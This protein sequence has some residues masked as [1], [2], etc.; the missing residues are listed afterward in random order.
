LVSEGVLKTFDSLTTVKDFTTPF[1]HEASLWSCPGSTPPLDLSIERLTYEVQRTASE[2]FPSKWYRPQPAYV[3][4]ISGHVLSKRKHGGAMGRIIQSRVHQLAYNIPT[5][6]TCTV[7]VTLDVGPLP[8]DDN[9]ECIGHGEFLYVPA[10]GV[11]MWDET[12]LLDEYDESDDS[13]SDLMNASMHLNTCA[14]PVGLKEPFKVRVITGGPEG[15][16]YRC[17]WIQKSTH[18]RMRGHRTF[19][20]IGTPL[21]S[22]IL[23]NVI[24]PLHD[25]QF[26]VSGDYSSATDN[27]DPRLSEAAARTISLNA[28]WS[29]R[30]TKDYVDSLIGHTLLHPHNF[31]DH[32]SLSDDTSRP[33]DP[34][35]LPD[36]ALPQKW[37]QLM[38]SPT[39]FPILC[40]VNAA[41]TRYAIECHTGMF[42]SLED[43]GILINGDD[44]GFVTDPS[45]YSIWKAVT[46][47]GGLSPSPGKNFTSKEFLVLNST[48]HQAT[49]NG[50][51]F[52]PFVNYGLLAGRSETGGKVID[53][54]KAIL[55]SADP[56][57]ADLSGMS[58]DLIKGFDTPSQVKLIQ[59]FIQAWKPT[60]DALLPSGLSYY[61]PKHLGGLGL[62]VVGEWT[63][64]RERYSFQQLRMAAFLEAS[65]DRQKQLAPLTTIGRSDCFSL[66]L[67]AQPKMD[68]VL[69]GI[70]RMWMRGTV[71]Q[72]V[73][74]SLTTSILAQTY[75][76][77]EAEDLFWTDEDGDKFS[78][79]EADADAK[80]QFDIWRKRWQQ[81]WKHCTHTQFSPLSSEQLAGSTPWVE[82]YFLQ[83]TVG[84]RSFDLRH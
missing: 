19:Q 77:L 9:H 30:V 66:W 27:L 37:G 63:G 64:K 68:A 26:Y 5:P 25:D 4:S 69:H 29:E 78:M 28:G 2:V 6:K 3:P 65:P 32:S 81:I 83:R 12:Y 82:H 61:L 22:E 33:G 38:G 51:H 58:H 49:P 59:R 47:A 1:D 62:P 41:L 7:T 42:T 80:L 23:T 75:M 76:G 34:G 11:E 39:S 44:I 54:C 71:V 45:G 21:T 20:L 14:R 31:R 43:S 74:T 79:F 36:W 84:D 72:D 18:Q 57:L 35:Y 40:L 67:E 46:T 56:R 73:M 52:I 10:P 13:P 55:G 70:D 48:M 24:H 60:L 53:T 15:L 17:K 50:W 16:Y 8:F